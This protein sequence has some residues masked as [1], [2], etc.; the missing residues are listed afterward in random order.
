MHSGNAG[1][2][3]WETMTINDSPRA[4][5]CQVFPRSENAVVVVRV[6]VCG[7]IEAVCVCINNKKQQSCTMTPGGAVEARV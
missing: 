6:C 4:R 1:L 5:K 2:C 7:N 3:N